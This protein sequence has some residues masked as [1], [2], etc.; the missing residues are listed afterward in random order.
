MKR[1]ISILLCA[2]LVFSCGVTASASENNTPV[3]FVPGFIEP[4]MSINID[5]WNE[6]RLWPFAV[7]SLVGKIVSDS[8]A[9][10]NRLVG[11]THGRF[12]VF[13]TRIGKDANDILYKLTCNPDGTS[14]YGVEALPQDPAKSSAGFLITHKG[15][16]YLSMASI[17]TDV[18][19]KEG[20]DR[21]FVFNYNSQLDSLTL[22]DQLRAFIKS[23][24]EYTGSDKVRICTH[25]YGGQILASYFYRYRKDCDVS[26]AVMIYPALEGTDAIKY[27]LE[28]DTDVHFGDVLK[29]LQSLL[30]SPTEIEKLTDEES[31]RCLSDFASNGLKQVVEMWR[32]WSSMYSLCSTEYYETLKKEF[33]DPVESAPIIRNNDI[34]HYDMMP[35]LGSIFAD[36]KSMGIDVS[37]IAGTGTQ[38]CLGGDDNTDVLLPV[39]YVT[40]ASCTKY[41]SH[42]S[43]GYKAKG[44]VCGN[45]NHNHVSPSMEVDASTA[46]LPENTW[47]VE[48]AYHGAYPNQDY[49]MSLIEELLLTDN[50]RDVHSDSRYPQFEYSDNVNMGIHFKF[51]NSSAGYISS[52]DSGIVI[53]N[54]NKAVPV[55]VNSITASGLDIKFPSNKVIFPG[56]S[57]TVKFKGEI[58]EVNAKRT[59]ITVRYTE[60]ASVNVDVRGFTVNNG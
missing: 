39:K 29:F 50:I 18:A 20:F 25:S 6:E 35:K 13:G 55:V 21:V 44:T 15:A 45:R 32:Y 52:E 10:V 40:G 22:A 17:V 4:V 60:G 59:D 56:Q 2:V 27:L 34:I 46:Y 47:F 48:G 7:S 16:K 1:I 12:D 5:K 33:L 14:K 38:E 26:K 30:Y 23:V 28:A 31:N 9:L 58:P 19:L 54:L 8:P 11:L 37:V 53:T 51:N 57:I 49:T 41:G 43:D 42:F 24:K 36:C 3:I